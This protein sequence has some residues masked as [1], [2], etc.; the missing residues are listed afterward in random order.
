MLPYAQ[1]GEN[2]EERRNNS[3]LSDPPRDNQLAAVE[4]FRI[5]HEVF[6]ERGG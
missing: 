3:G 1:V 4:S 2:R 6:G 5:G